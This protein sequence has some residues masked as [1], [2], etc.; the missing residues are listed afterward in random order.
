MPKSSS[1]GSPVGGDQD[2]GRLEVAVDDQVLVRV[3]D[4]RADA[5]EEVEPLRRS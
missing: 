2:V 5:P 4:G 1:L 3:L